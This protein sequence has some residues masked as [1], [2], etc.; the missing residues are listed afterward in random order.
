MISKGQKIQH[1]TVKFQGDSCIPVLKSYHV[2]TGG[3]GIA[4]VKSP[5]TENGTV[6]FGSVQDYLEKYRT[7]YDLSEQLLGISDRHTENKANLK[8]MV[9]TKE[10]AIIVYSVAQPQ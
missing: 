8:N 1:K 5:G 4:K 10:K 6:P 2:G 7:G 3:W 9:I